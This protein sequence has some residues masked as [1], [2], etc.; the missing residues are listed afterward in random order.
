MGIFSRLFRNSPE[1]EFQREIDSQ[2]SGGDADISA[3]YAYTE[4]GFRLT[5]KDVFSIAGRGT[6]VTGVVSSGEISV[7]D[8]VQIVRSGQIIL[9]SR[10]NGIEMFRKICEKAVT[11]ENV[12]ILLNN[13]NRNQ[14][15]RGDILIK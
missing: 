1:E 13:V 15:M 6:V 2:I 9:S 4:I 14:L 3:D 11:G 7:G 5:V 8:T 12:G 10:V